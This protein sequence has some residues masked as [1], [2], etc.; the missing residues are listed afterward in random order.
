MEPCMISETFLSFSEDNIYGAV[1][2][3]AITMIVWMDD[4]V[5]QPL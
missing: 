5:E 1:V 3:A 2:I 4:K